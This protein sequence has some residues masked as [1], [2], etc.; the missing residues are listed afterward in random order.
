MNAR[1][2]RFRRGAPPEPSLPLSLPWAGPARAG[3]PLPR[4]MAVP[5]SLRSSG[6]HISLR[7]WSDQKAWL[8]ENGVELAPL[9]RELIDT[10]RGRE[11][12]IARGKRQKRVYELAV[13]REV[14]RRASQVANAR[15][16]ARAEAL[17]SRR[18]AMD[19][20]RSAYQAWLGA[21]SR[22]RFDS[23]PPTHHDRVAWVSSRVERVPVL[24][25]E[26]PALLVDELDGIPPEGL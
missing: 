9:V 7:I 24:R 18:R 15:L 11:S 3:P 17:E 22:D 8:E 13:L 1:R 19:K 20:L 4:Y 26:L 6:T 12:A 16:A 2:T 25:F 5:P 23:R 21:I 10:L 14:G